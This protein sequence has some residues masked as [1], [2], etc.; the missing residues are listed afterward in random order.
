MIPDRPNPNWYPFWLYEA[1]TLPAG[2]DSLEVSFQ[3]PRS[4]NW[5]LQ[6]A[7]AQYPTTGAALPTTWQDI[8]VQ[9]IDTFTNWKYANEPIPFFLFT[10]PSRFDNFSSGDVKN[11]QVFLGKS[12]NRQFI[13]K[14]GFSLKFTQFSAV[15]P[16]E[17]QLALQG[18]MILEKGKLY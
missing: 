5:L 6:R 17:L 15:A 10:S 3:L 1:I 12:F 8:R 4:G 14:T 16:I 18:K 2:K 11:Q 9:L 7:T 13:A